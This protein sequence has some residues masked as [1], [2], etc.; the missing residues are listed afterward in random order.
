MKRNLL[1]VALALLGGASG[2]AEAQIRPAYA[3]PDKAA[4]GVRLGETPFYLTPYVGVAIGY[5]DNLFQS[6]IN[7]RSSNVFLLSPGFSLEARG[8]SSVFQVKYQGQVG[9]YGNSEDD[10]YVDHAARAVYDVAFGR[11]HFL[12]VGVDYVRGHDPR[13][14]T[15]RP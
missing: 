12:R 15:D 10:N 6:S 14:S 7:E 8:A 2:V 9:R 13:G 4:G 3:Y 1:I 11:R 5:D